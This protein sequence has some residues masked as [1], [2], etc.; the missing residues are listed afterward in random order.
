VQQ[1]QNAS[2]HKPQSSQADTDA[3]DHFRSNALSEYG[4]PMSEVNTK[5]ALDSHQNARRQYFDEE[6]KHASQSL[7]V[8]NSASSLRSGSA[9][10][11]DISVVSI[12]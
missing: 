6:G 10:V 9:R 3:Q 5:R 7:G 11:A 4:E 1:K 12:S 8:V 2:R